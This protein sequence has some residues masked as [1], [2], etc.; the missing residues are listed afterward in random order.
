MKKNISNKELLKY[1][2][3]LN[4]GSGVL[5]RLKIIY[6]PVVCPFAELIS[7]VNA[8]EKVGDV[9]CG[10][11]QFCLLLSRFASPSAVYGI[12]INER[13]VSNAESLFKKYGSANFQ[14]EL[15]DGI[16]FP[17]KIGEMDIIFLNDVLHH[18]PKNAQERFIR[19]LI[20]KM[21]PG[22]RFVLKDIDGGKPLVYMN[23]LH[24]LIFAGEIGNELT[25]SKA[26]EWLENNNL[27]ITEFEKKKMYVYHHYTIVAQKP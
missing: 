13:L 14:F 15:F 25:S 17:D 18:V 1:L 27:I 5:D 20:K 26:K 24:D 12:E 7:L 10:S 6:R 16:H 22:A 21:K 8:G 9:G 4:F 11:G 19:D 3:S 2:K 23:K